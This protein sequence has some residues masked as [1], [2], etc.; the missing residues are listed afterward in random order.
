MR[1]NDFNSLLESMDHFWYSEEVEKMY[2]IAKLFTMAFINFVYV[3]FI[4]VIALPIVLGYYPFI[5]DFPKFPG[6]FIIF[7]L[8][9]GFQLL[10]DVIVVLAVDSLFLCVAFFVYPQFKML[11]NRLEK[12]ATNEEIMYEE[13]RIC[14]RHHK[15]LLKYVFLLNHFFRIIYYCN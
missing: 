2:K 5:A 11:N 6:S 7:A 12:L 15:F 14:I 8:A 1:E 10:Y 13:A 9:Q 3:A 4:F